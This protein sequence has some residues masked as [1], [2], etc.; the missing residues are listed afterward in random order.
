[1]KNA[2]PM[3]AALLL[4][5]PAMAANF[6]VAPSSGHQPIKAQIVN[7][8]PSHFEINLKKAANMGADQKA[9]TFAM[10]TTS[11]VPAQ[12]GDFTAETIS[13]QKPDKYH[14]VFNLTEKPEVLSALKEYGCV[15][16]TN[17]PALPPAKS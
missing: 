1:M 15:I 13:Y 3:L 6:D 8:N 2:L 11:A 7:P 17:K 16:I 10:Y 4:A 5:S 12:C 9:K 14:R